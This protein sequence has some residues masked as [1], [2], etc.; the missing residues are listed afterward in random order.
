M[1]ASSIIVCAFIECMRNACK[2]RQDG[3]PFLSV[4]AE[5]VSRLGSVLHETLCV[6]EAADLRLKLLILPLH[7]LR[8]CDLLLLPT[9]KLQSLA[10][11][12]NLLGALLAYARLFLPVLIDLRICRKTCA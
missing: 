1:Y 4:L 7:R 6:R 9:Q 10:D 11:V 2:C 12:I 3:E 8:L 5:E